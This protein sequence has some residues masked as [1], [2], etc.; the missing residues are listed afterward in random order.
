MFGISQVGNLPGV[1]YHEEEEKVDEEGGGY[2]DRHFTNC[3][4][5]CKVF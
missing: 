4:H 3:G 2:Y 1:L 5:E